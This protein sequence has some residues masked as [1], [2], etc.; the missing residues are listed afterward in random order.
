MAVRVYND[1]IRDGHVTRGS[2]GV[3]WQP[4]TKPEA[5]KAMGY[6][7]GVILSDIH[8]GGPADKAGVKADDI[9]LALNDKPIKDGDDLMGRVAD[10]PVGTHALLTV[11][12]DGKKL[13]FKLVV[14]DRM[15]VF[16]DDPRV[17]GEL[18][19]PTAVPES[20]KAEV[21]HLVKFGIQLR[22][23]TDDEKGLTPEKRGVIVTRVEPG[24]F[25][26][27]VIGMMD[28]DIITAVNRTAVNSIEDVKK[29]QGTLK[30]GD[31][32]AFR[33]I[34]T[35]G[36]GARRGKAAADAPTPSILL[37]GTLPE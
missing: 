23:L 7:H 34:R 14:E 9:L 15:K 17:M 36:G 19:T 5:L 21:S 11:D 26:A 28:R 24:S 27:D 6:D 37:S 29:V 33:V 35:T 13:D 10:M 31:P 4:N 20:S 32:V 18:A 30:P 3:T 25:A 2:I 8:K 22:P 1:V 16:S 12:R